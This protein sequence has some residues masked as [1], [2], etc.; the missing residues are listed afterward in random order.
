[1]NRLST[2]KYTLVFLLFS[3]SVFARQCEDF[4]DVQTTC[5]ESISDGISDIF[6]SDDE[7]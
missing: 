5:R 3:G 6:N 1:M 7:S 4:D 2:A